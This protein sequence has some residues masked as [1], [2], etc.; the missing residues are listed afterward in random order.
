M[1]FT[2]N[3]ITQDSTIELGG[4]P[5]RKGA[6]YELEYANN[7]NVGTATV[8]IT[9]EER[10]FGS[11]SYNFEISAKSINPAVTLSNTSYTYDGKEKKPTVTVKDGTSVLT[12]GV[13][14][15]YIKS[16]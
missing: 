12:E 1:T 16:K 3:E 10:Y 9:G 5:L 6:D 7:I 14:K 11:L 13:I 4:K 15:G 2:G 8:T